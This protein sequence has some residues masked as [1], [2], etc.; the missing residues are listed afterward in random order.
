VII[1]ATLHGNVVV[2]VRSVCDLSRN[3]GT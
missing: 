2:K 3:A 1:K